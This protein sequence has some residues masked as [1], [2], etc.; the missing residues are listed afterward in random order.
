MSK[1]QDQKI[2]KE[3][4][5]PTSK[6]DMD[7]FWLESVFPD[8]QAVFAFS[9]ASPTELSRHA[10]FALDTNVLLAPYLVEPASLKDIERIY[11]KLAQQDR[12]FVP[13]QAA[14]EYGKNRGKKIADVYQ[15]VHDRASNLPAT[16]DLNCPILE[17]VPE[18]EAVKKCIEE[19]RTKSKTL[20]E[21]LGNLKETL[22]AW[23]WN[24][25]VS[26]LYRELFTGSRIIN[27]AKSQ[28]EV[29]QDLGFRTKHAVPPGYKDAGKPDGGIGDLLI[30]LSLIDLGK[31][32]SKPV[33]F[34][35]NEEKADWYLRSGK[36]TVLPR[37]EL[38]LEFHRETN[39][40]L[41]LMDWRQ[42][43]ECQEASP[44]TLRNAVR[45]ASNATWMSMEFTVRIRILFDQLINIF[46]EFEKSLIIDVVSEQPYIL[47]ERLSQLVTLFQHSVDE[48][49]SSDD[50]RCLP[51]LE[52]AVATLREIMDLNRLLEYIEA[53]QKESGDQDR[54]RLV[55]QCEAF[56][57]YYSRFLACDQ[58]HRNT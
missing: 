54:Q 8:P 7:P 28:E 13:A 9:C 56:R 40:N 39:Q 27:H 49:A 57:V 32:H 23:G 45:A 1:E 52:G 55:D 37:T 38:C 50:P 22:A 4:K 48:Y 42:F 26:S 19:L 2:G 58:H 43:L 47:D 18:Y 15:V 33:I 12:L 17:G 31:K 51:Q 44:E 14:R 53:R 5:P 36:E 3:H 30:W 29:M 20:R 35:T 21:A 10:V 34:V 6:G 16:G 25:R 46:E 24:D 11:R 41:A